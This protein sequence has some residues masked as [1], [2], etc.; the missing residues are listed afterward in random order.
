MIVVKFLRLSLQAFST[1]GMITVRTKDPE[2]QN[3]IGNA[4]GL[5]FKDIKL[6]NLMYSCNGGCFIYIGT[7][8]CNQTVNIFS[9]VRNI[10]VCK[11]WQFQNLKFGI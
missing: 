3:V 6:A 8:K 2:Y 5:S 10:Y 7:V 4:L 1:N 9:T 11:L